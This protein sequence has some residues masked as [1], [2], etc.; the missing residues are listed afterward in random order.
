MISLFSS[1]SLREVQG[2]ERHLQ[3]EMAKNVK[4]KFGANTF[5]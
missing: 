1:I 2:K 3:F 5:L 4:L